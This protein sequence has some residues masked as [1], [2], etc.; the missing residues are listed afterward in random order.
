MGCDGARSA[1]RQSIGRMLQGD[2]AN[3][4]WGVMD[5]L[6][7]TDFPDIR[8]KSLIQSA[9]EGSIVLIPREGGYLVRIYVELDKLKENERVAARN[10]SIDQLIAAAQR[11][12]HPYSLDVKEVAWWSVYEIGQR[13]CDR[14]DDVEPHLMDAKAKRAA[15]GLVGRLE[16]LGFHR[17][18]DVFCRP[19]LGHATFHPLGDAAPFNRRV[20]VGDDRILRGPERIEHPRP[21]RIGIGFD[22]EDGGEFWGGRPFFDLDQAFAKLHG[23]TGGIFRE[24]AV[25]AA[26]VVPQLA[27]LLVI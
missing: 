5:V 10:I 13:L 1:V 2:S 8:F 18:G 14:F 24:E 15:F 16:E 9:D 20:A 11:I 6:V 19:H 4:A 17:G 22:I 27:G 12:F 25:R 23:G 7:V 21:G 26:R 3:H